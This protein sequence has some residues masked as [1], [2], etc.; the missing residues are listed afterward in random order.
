MTQPIVS[1][2]FNKYP[3]KPHGHSLI[4]LILIAGCSS[5]TTLPPII[6]I[7]PPIQAVPEMKPINRTIADDQKLSLNLPAEVQPPKVVAIQSKA[8]K[9]KLCKND[10]VVI[11][12][13]MS[14]RLRRAQNAANTNNSNVDRNKT[15]A[16]VGFFSAF[17]QEIEK[18][19]LKKTLQVVDRNT[20]EAELRNRRDN[21][22]RSASYIGGFGLDEEKAYINELYRKG[23]IREGERDDG[24]DDIERRYAMGGKNRTSNELADNAEVIR[25]VQEGRVRAKYLLI[26]NNFSISIAGSEHSAG[27]AVFIP[28]KYS[29]NSSVKEFFTSY[30]GSE[31]YFPMTARSPWYQAVTSAKLI[32]VKTGEIVWLG[33]IVV[34][35]SNVDTTKKYTLEFK[36]QTRVSNRDNIRYDFQQYIDM[37]E[38]QTAECK[39]Y[40]SHLTEAIDDAM[41]TTTGENKKLALQAQYSKQNILTESRDNLSQCIDTLQKIYTSSLSDRVMAQAPQTSYSSFELSSI[42][43]QILD[44]LEIPPASP[45]R[46]DQIRTYERHRVTLARTAAS[47]LLASL[48]V[49][50]SCR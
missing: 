50:Q 28:V 14:E 46:K 36:G 31:T 35:S 16:T 7:R 23:Y 30:P 24:L 19:L 39:R 45:R 17:E 47:K 10:R 2:V 49:K 44:P 6:Q 5:Q 41:S 22:N 25:A 43:P 4:L 15:F 40:Q 33:S 26:I 12:I 20:L 13:P 42:S 21:T 18:A 29:N 9:S 32:E 1:A 37:L 48:E 27:T 3:V 34:H 38:S 11:G 8:L